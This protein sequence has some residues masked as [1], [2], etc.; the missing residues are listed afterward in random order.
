MGKYILRGW[1]GAWFI[2]CL[3]LLVTGMGSAFIMATCLVVN[4]ISFLS[5]YW[6]D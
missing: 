2:V 5:T 4:L 3:V 6:V 1:S